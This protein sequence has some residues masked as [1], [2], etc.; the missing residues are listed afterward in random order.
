MATE[1][2]H[3]QELASRRNRRPKDSAGDGKPQAK[4]PQAKGKEP[5]SAT[6]RKQSTKSQLAQARRKSAKKKSLNKKDLIK[7]AK[8]LPLAFTAIDLSKDGMQFVVIMVSIIADLFTLIPA[9][10]GFFAF[11]FSIVIW[12]LYAVSGHLNKRVG[13]KV[14]VT[15]V[16]QFAEIFG[17]V[18]N[19]LPFFTI[20]ALVNYWFALADRKAQQED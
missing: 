12:V 4:K 14:I 18:I 13:R 19:A 10:G 11:V 16:S 3:Y 1:Q 7:S 17:F 6:R 9:V 20:S 15:S 8:Q 2:E 5:S